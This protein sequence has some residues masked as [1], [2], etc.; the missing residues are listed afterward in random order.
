VTPQQLQHRRLAL[1]LT[2][3]EF[4]APLGIA[5]NEILRWERGMLP[6]PSG[7]V[8]ELA[9]AYVELCFE[10]TAGEG[11]ASARIADR[12]IESAIPSSDEQRAAIS[13]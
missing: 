3:A 12:R 1:G 13:A 7:F 11:S 5:A 8:L 2:R 4:A 6:M 9:V 10:A